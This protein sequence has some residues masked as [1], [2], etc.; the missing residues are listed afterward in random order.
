MKRIIL[1]SAICDLY[2][3]ENNATCQVLDSGMKCLCR[4][5][6]SGPKCSKRESFDVFKTAHNFHILYEIKK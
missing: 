5:E 3:C 6:Y 1:L 4:E 2:G